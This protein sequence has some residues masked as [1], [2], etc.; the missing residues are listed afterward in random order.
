MRLRVALEQ[1]LE[2]PLRAAEDVEP[3]MNDSNPHLATPGRYYLS[4]DASCPDAAGPF[5]LSI[6]ITS[7]GMIGV[8][9]VACSKVSSPDLARR[10]IL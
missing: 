8:V 6:W 1:L 2:H 5:W 3:V 10:M 4:S 9:S 7:P